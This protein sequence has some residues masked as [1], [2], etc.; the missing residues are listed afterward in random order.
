MRKALLREYIN[1][2]GHLW[3]DRCVIDIATIQEHRNGG[4][5]HERFSLFPRNVLRWTFE[6]GKEADVAILVTFI[7]N[8]IIEFQGYNLTDSKVIA[9]VSFDDIEAGIWELAY[10]DRVEIVCMLKSA[11][12]GD[13]IQFLFCSKQVHIRM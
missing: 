3:V 1:T 12:Y 9:E 6:E 13:L 4:I 10:T 11:I 2:E 7:S 5:A 8:D